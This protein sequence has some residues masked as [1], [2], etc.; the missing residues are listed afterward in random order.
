VVYR[1]EKTEGL[2]GTPWKHVRERNAFG[3]ARGKGGLS[4]RK[5]GTILRILSDPSADGC[6]KKETAMGEK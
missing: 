2:V 1:G 6:Q 5:I 3:K 4:R